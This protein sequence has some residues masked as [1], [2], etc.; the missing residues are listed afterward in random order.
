MLT[1]GDWPRG[2][3]LPGRQRGWQREPCQYPETSK[4]VIREPRQPSFLH[5]P[6]VTACPWH[7]GRGT[8]GGDS[9]VG[10]VSASRTPCDSLMR[11]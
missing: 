5:C 7:A 1:V 10:M 6:V 11:E 8:G 9:E 3:P 4:E 2:V